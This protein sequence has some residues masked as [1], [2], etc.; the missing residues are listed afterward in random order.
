MIQILEL[1]TNEGTRDQ[2]S[3]SNFKSLPE[4]R[5]GGRR[6][7]TKK[8]INLNLNFFLPGRRE[9]SP[10]VCQSGE[11]R[12]TPVDLALRHFF[13]RIYVGKLSLET[14]KVR[15]RTIKHRKCTFP[16]YRGGNFY[17]LGGKSSETDR[18]FFF[19][20][21]GVFHP[22]PFPGTITGRDLLLPLLFAEMYIIYSFF[23]L[24]ESGKTA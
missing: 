16:H 6:L 19:L 23:V 17:P 5:E 9:Q 24:Q 10:L 20:F 1:F 3:R 18:R 15:H 13:D 2:L 21:S 11:D 4:K 8:G 22:S 14:K 7:R 12:P